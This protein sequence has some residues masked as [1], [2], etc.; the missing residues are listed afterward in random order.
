[1]TSNAHLKE[2][3]NTPKSKPIEI[4]VCV[5]MCLAVST[6]KMFIMIYRELTSALK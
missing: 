2:C 5:C 4:I 3:P 6:V 1:M